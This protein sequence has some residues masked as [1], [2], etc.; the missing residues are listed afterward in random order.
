[1]KAVLEFNLN[2]PDDSVAHL[3]AVKSLNMAIVLWEI[4]YNTKKNIQWEIERDNLDGYTTLDRLY[5]K[6]AE[7][8]DD[9]GIKIDALIS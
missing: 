3:R 5:E 4:V 2:D 9:N 7:S 6:I 8:L 1:M